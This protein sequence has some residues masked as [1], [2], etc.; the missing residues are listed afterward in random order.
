MIPGED[1]EL[2]QS[3]K[4]ACINRLV[5]PGEDEESCSRQGKGH[6]LEVSDPR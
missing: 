2:H 6:A 4:G 5:I 3:R 1:E